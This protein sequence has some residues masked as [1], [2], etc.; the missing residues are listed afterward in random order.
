[1]ARLRF[2]HPHRALF[3]S[4]PW[5]GDCRAYVTSRVNGAFRRLR[6]LAPQAWRVTHGSGPVN[7][8]TFDGR[9]TAELRLALALITVIIAAGVSNAN[10]LLLP[11]A[12]G[13]FAYSAAVC[14][15]GLGWQ[16]KRLPADLAQYYPVDAGVFVLFM[17]FADARGTFASLFAI[18]L[19]VFAVSGAAITWGFSAGLRLTVA[20]VGLF[21]ALILVRASIANDLPVTQT[22]LSF[23]CL[24]GVGTIAARRGGYQFTVRSRLILLR[25]AGTLANPR[26]GVDQTIAALLERLREFYD[27]ETCVLTTSS[28]RSAEVNGPYRADRYQNQTRKN[29]PLSIDALPHL[30]P[31]TLAVYRRP[32]RWLR[33]PARVWYAERLNGQVVDCRRPVQLANV[34]PWLDRVGLRSWLSVPAYADRYCIGRLHLVG[35]RTFQPSDARFVLQVLESGMLL[36]EHIRLIDQLASTAALRERQ[37]VARD[38]HD[39]VVQ[40]Y[41]GLQLGLIAVQRILRSGD[42]ATAEAKVTQL[43]DLTGMTIDELRS[44]IRSLKSEPGHSAGDLI[45]ALHHQATRFAE[46]TGIPVDIDG[47]DTLQCSDRLAAELFQMTLEALSNVRRH[48]TATRAAVRFKNDAHY[49]RLQ[50]EN[51]GPS[52]KGRATPFVPQSLSERAAA[53]GGYVTVDRHG[54]GRSL[55]EITIPR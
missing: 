17:S 21:A 20:T 55:V 43:V 15:A 36:V 8:G 9:L 41:V 39:S 19:F 32:W 30:P 50:V 49:V 4:A 10:P 12:A 46:D 24:V 52:S 13:Y 34:A 40:P 27:A 1:M 3:P 25:D 51:S 47:L 31:N 45:G 2:L 44:G 54:N 38:I 7:L 48:T 28:D 53:L 33:E 6:A 35:K 42:L 29:P 18:Y 16:Q 37:R 26:F 11:T 14:V 5:P 22:L 23:G